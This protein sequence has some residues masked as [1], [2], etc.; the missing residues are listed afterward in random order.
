M[1]GL[2]QGSINLMHLFWPCSDV[3]IIRNQVMSD[4]NGTVMRKSLILRQLKAVC[5]FDR[6]GGTGQVRMFG[7]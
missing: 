2:P 5:F 7:L 4:T 6:S 1:R 3:V